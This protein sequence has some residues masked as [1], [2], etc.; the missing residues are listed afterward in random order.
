[1]S[2]PAN[3]PINDPLVRNPASAGLGGQV[4]PGQEEPLP[5]LE[6]VQLLWYRKWTI[7]AITILVGVAGWVWVNQQTPVYRAQSTIMLGSPMGITSPEMMWV[8]YFNK[9]KAPDEIEVLKSRSLAEQL[10]KSLDLLSYPVGVIALTTNGKTDATINMVEDAAVT[11]DEVTMVLLGAIPLAARPDAGSAAVIGF[12][13]G[14]T[15]HVLLGSESLKT[16][17]TI[18][19]ESAMVE[20]SQWFRPRVERAYSD[21]RSRV[22]IDDARAFFS[23]RR[24]HYDIIISEPSHPWVS[25]VSNLYSSEFYALVKSQLS[26]TGIFAQW[27]HMRKINPVLVASV[28]GAI[29][30]E[31]SRFAVYNTNGRDILILASDG[32]DLELDYQRVADIPELARELERIGVRHAQDLTSRKLGS[33]QL[34]NSYYG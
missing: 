10:V 9:L 17:D 33:A 5:I 32:G 12:G 29:S 15:T 3:D 26:D 22:H 20:A 1:M 7:L 24:K 14:L 23:T 16:V 30:K 21:S 13:S 11:T 31:F 18:E 8:A 27:L 25:G 6:Y 34:M 19:I 2:L 28:V 4:G